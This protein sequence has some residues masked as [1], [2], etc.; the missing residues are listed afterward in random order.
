M[1]AASDGSRSQ[2]DP[3]LDR[4]LIQLWPAP[5]APDAVLRRTSRTAAYWHDHARA[6][7]TQAELATRKAEQR[8]HVDAQAQAELAERERQR[9]AEQNL[10]WGGR[11]PA[12][13]VLEIAESL[14]LSQ[15][16]RALLDAVVAA[17]PQQQRAV[18][19]F[20]VRQAYTEAG[21]NGISW[22]DAALDALDHA[23][24]L[25]APFDDPA[26]MWRALAEDP[27]VPSTTI[28][29]P[30]GQADWSQQHMTLPALLHAA[31]PDPLRAAIATLVQAAT[32]VGYDRRHSLLE[33][34]RRVL[35]R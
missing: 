16:D 19:R 29:S 34:A 35:A 27:H 17:G 26:A 28:R 12:R 30:D 15:Y 24:P 20:A 5:P 25:P 11:I 22:I 21:L 1:D 33:A 3:V 31:E 7:P 18:A 32:G 10:R 13:E 6:L 8:A 23:T 2:D 14:Q 9:L 4:Y